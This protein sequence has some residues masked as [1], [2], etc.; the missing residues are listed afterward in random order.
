MQRIVIAVAALLLS[1]C[2]SKSPPAGGEAPFGF[3]ALAAALRARGAQ[4][5]PGEAVE[6]PFFSVAGRFLAVNGE[7]VQVFEYADAEAARAEAATV[8]PDGGTIGT[9]KPFWA[10]PPHFYRRDRVIVLYTG[11]AGRV[12]TPLEA[13]M[14][15]QFAG[16]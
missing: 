1:A 13:V 8:S 3:E 10:A 14:G 5:L 12:R 4:V 16:R 7:D 15:P 11:D 9:A 6:Q 2:A